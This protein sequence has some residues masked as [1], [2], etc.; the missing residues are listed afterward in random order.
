MKKNLII[1]IILIIVLGANLF[2]LYR[3]SHLSITPTKTA[4]DQSSNSVAIKNETE[5]TLS[6]PSQSAQNENPTDNAPTALVWPINRAPERVTKKP[7]G[8]YITPQNSPVKPE[9]F[10]GYHT[11]TDFEVFPDELNKDVPIQ[12]ICSGPILEKRIAS[13]YG[14]VLV[15]SCTLNNAPVTVVYGHLNLQSIPKKPGD[16]LSQSEQI[17][18]LGADKSLQTDGERKH[19]HLSIHK[20]SS[21]NIKGY[22][23]NKKDLSAWIDPCLY[24][25]QK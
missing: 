25:C 14:G 24:L 23:G 20:G 10:S 6:S 18:L 16:E 17:G 15:Q 9:R 1:A 5:T 4:A 2:R 22:V 19:L 11:G 3:N 7:F 13:G 12:A 21:A 8:I